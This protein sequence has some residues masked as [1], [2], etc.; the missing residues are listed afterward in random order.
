MKKFLSKIFGGSWEEGGITY[1][2]PGWFCNKRQDIKW[3]FERDVV[4]FW[5]RI[6][7]KY[8][9]IKSIIKEK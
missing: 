1:W 8:I 6:K 7:I 9:K 2:V 5:L 3:F 4:L